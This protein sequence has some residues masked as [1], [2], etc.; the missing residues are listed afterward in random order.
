MLDFYLIEDSDTKPSFPEKIGLEFVHG[1]SEK[2]FEEYQSLELI[3]KNIRSK[4]QIF[5]SKN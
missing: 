1:I 2:E 5:L 3:D 4:S